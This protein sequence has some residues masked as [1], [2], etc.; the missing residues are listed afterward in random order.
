MGPTREQ[1]VDLDGTRVLV[2]VH[3]NGSPAVVLE[4]A[5]VASRRCGTWSSRCCHRPSRSSHT[6][7]PVSDA[8]TQ[9][10]HLGPLSSRDPSFEGSW[11]SSTAFMDRSFSL[12]T[13]WELSI[14][15]V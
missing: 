8:A 2:R 4:R 12:V 1:F 6:T 9:R 13:P 10:R 5:W 11:N 7:G 14:Q 3:G 15:S